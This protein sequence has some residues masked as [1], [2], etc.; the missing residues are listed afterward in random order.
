M[1]H[2]KL[3]YTDA[4]PYEKVNA[5]WTLE[6]KVPFVDTENG[7]TLI[8]SLQQF[9]IGKM[10]IFLQKSMINTLVDLTMKSRDCVEKV[11]DSK[12]ELVIG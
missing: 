10:D 6:F 12:K 11:L 4:S 9:T 2:L 5:Q 1:R 3:T 7:M 8:M